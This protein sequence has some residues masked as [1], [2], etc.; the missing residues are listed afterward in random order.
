VQEK[1]EKTKNWKIYRKPRGISNTTSNNSNKKSS[2]NKEINILDAI[3]TPNELIRETLINFT[4]GFLGNSI[5]VFVAKELDFLVLI[6]YIVYYILIS[7]IVNRNKYE[8]I[9]GKFI[10]LPGSAAAGAFTGY[11]LAQ[12]ISNFL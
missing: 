2:L 1:K 11:K 7:Y 5:V 10:I 9:L 12:I 8:T 3:T 4:W 6:N